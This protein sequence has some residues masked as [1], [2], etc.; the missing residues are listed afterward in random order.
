MT[1]NEEV[2]ILDLLQPW[3]ISECGCIHNC[4]LMEM[5]FKGSKMTW[6]NGQGRMARSW[7]ILDRC[8]INSNFLN[9]FPNVFFQVLARTTSNHS[10][11]VIQMGEDLFRY[12]P[13]PF[14]FQFMW[15]DHVDFLRHMQGVWK[16]ERFGIGLSNLA[17]KLKR[18]KAALKVESMCFWQNE[19]YD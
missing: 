7:A 9:S 15:T 1:R 19:Y 18:V 8:F 13:S 3:K 4:G 17:F 14:R 5:C 2:A 11:L 6:S 16:K 12:D 10:P